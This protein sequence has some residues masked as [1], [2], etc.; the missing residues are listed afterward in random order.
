MRS[1]LVGQEFG[2]GVVMSL[3]GRSRRGDRLW[4]LQCKCGQ[5]YEAITNDLNTGNT[6]SCGCSRIGKNS[7]NYKGFEGITG[8]SWYNIQKNARN[9]GILFS[10]SIEEAWDKYKQQ[11]GRCALT[12]W[13]ITLCDIGRKRTKDQNTASL[14]RIDNDRGYVGENIQWLHKD[15]NKLKSNLCESYFVEIC[16]AIARRKNAILNCCI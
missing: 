14:D 3:V 15:V 8:D 13:P 11:D 2:S 10:I 12:D 16:Q 4:S 7:V 6:G 1:S 9:R 5:Y